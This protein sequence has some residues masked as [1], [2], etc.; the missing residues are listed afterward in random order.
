MTDTLVGASVWEQG[1]YNHLLSHVE[2][3]RGILESYRDAAE[4]SESSAFR[5]LVNL[6][7]EDEIRHH[8]RFSELAEALRSDAELSADPPVVP[9]LDWYK[10]DRK[11]ISELT[12]GLI[13]QEKAD[14]KELERLRRE[15]K[16]V[17]DTTMWVLLVKLME[18]DTAKH[19]EILSFIRHHISL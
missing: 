4:R 7:V 17:K 1:I 2:T 18:A 11:V 16:D 6:I 9:R 14:A 3:E 5:Y 19:L 8:K 15:L 13:A 12:D 10:A